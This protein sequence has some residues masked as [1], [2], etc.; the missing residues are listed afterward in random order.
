[1]GKIEKILKASENHGTP[2][3]LIPKS[4]S[5]VEPKR[6]LDCGDSLIL[7]S[8]REQG[9]CIDCNMKFTALPK[10]KKWKEGML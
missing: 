1:M 8:E 5:E 7:V 4:P 6:C 2:K 3:R 10:H 9:Y